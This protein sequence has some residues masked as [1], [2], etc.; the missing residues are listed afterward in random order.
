VGEQERGE[1]LSYD[2]KKKQFVKYLG[3]ISATEVDFSPDGKW[4]AYV[5]YPQLEL[6][7]SRID[8]SQRLQ[9]T[10]LPLIAAMPRWS[11]DGETI[12]FSGWTGKTLRTYL[13]QAQGGDPEPLLPEENKN[14]DDPNWS[15]DGKSL[16]LSRT[17]LVGNSSDFDIAIVDLTSRRVTPL[18]GSVGFFAPR[19]S[20]N[21][22]YISAFS[23]DGRKIVLFDLSKQQG[24]EL[25]QGNELQYPQWS[26][27]GL[28]IYFAE[29]K[30]SWPEF[31]RIRISTRNVESL[32]S[33]KDIPRPTLPYGAEW[34][35]IT[36][37]GIP[38]IM[39]DAGIREV[40]SLDL[41][42]P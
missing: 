36:P 3:G 27:D 14:E 7:K 31:D 23:A 9:L 13:V 25:F 4:V 15:K 33:L 34:N 32:A 19:Y 8:G 5:E 1:L 20:P 16:V 10:R 37:E 21:G 12:A 26:R 42:L 40:Y 35:G 30:N 11:S 41:Q 2:T 17:P 38:L 29:T 6:W 39:R 18:P 22:R 28:Y 24:S